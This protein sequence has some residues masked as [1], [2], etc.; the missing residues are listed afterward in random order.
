M[1]RQTDYPNADMI[2]FVESARWCSAIRRNFSRE[3]LSWVLSVDD[4]IEEARQRKA[5][6]AIVEFSTSNIFAFAEKLHTLANNSQNLK[7]F[8]IGDDGLLTWRP[9]LRAIGVAASYWSFIQVPDLVQAV[10]QHRLS[11]PTREPSI[12]QSVWASLP[13]PTAANRNQP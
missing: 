2:V 13:W 8:T 7:L 11:C 9:V 1:E 10:N 3:R 5:I 6:V 12:E 4:L